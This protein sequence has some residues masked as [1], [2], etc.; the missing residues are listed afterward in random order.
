MSIGSGVFDPRGSKNLGVPLTRLVALT[1]VLHYRA[2]CDGCTTDYLTFSDL[3]DKADSELFCNMRRSYHWLH[4]VL[5]PLRMVDNLGVRGHPLTYLNVIP[6][7]TKIICCAFL[8]WFY[9]RF[10]G[11]ITFSTTIYVLFCST[12][13]FFVLFVLLLIAMSC[14]C[15]VG[16]RLSH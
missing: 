10:T 8:V 16:V 1:S 12:V 3:L 13:F 6:T 11:F 7:F 4:H 15:S 14:H 9:I 5:P 2:D